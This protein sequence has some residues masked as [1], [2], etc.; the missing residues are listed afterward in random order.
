MRLVSPLLKRVVYPALHHS[1][2]LGRI[3]P[4][5]GFTVVNYHGVIPAGYSSDDKFLDGNLI[6][7]DV[8]RQQLQFLK[9][10]YSVIAP[11]DFRDCIEQG[12][13]LPPRSVLVTCDDGLLNN[14]TD[15][16]PLLREEKI[17]C[18]FF[19]TSASCG[20][21]PGILWYEEL[22]HLLRSKPLRDLTAMLPFAIGEPQPA[23]QTFQGEWWN[24]VQR[25][26]RLSAEARS[27]WMDEVRANSG[28]RPAPFEKRWR[29]LNL[30]ELKRLAESGMSIGAHTRTHPVLSESSDE[31]ARREIQDSKAEIEGT[32]GLPIWAFAY[33]FGNSATM[34]AREFR[35]AQAAGYPCA[36]LNVEHW[37]GEESNVLAF[38]RTHVT[39][40]MTLPEFAAHV[41]GI[42][43]R[44]QRAAGN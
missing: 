40:D 33:P 25:A 37:A 20:N 14:L 30:R 27:D 42:H 4:P 3:H 13:P 29:L 7:A 10:N 12:E 35:L 41:S 16:L 23:S 36:F 34:G 43:V 18:L 39:A 9:S 1:G 17:S 38:P 32:L 31:D 11:E 15:M 21:D 19:V 28:L 24:A 5:R 22:Y 8:L 2:V 44:L 26:S 6:R